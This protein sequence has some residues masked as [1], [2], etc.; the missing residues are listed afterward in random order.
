MYRTTRVRFLLI[1]LFFFIYNSI[2]FFQHYWGNET[3]R[4]Y[5]AGRLPKRH[6]VRTLVILMGNLRGG[7]LAWKSLH[8]NVLDANNAD[9]A[10]MIGEPRNKVDEEK[11]RNSSLYKR[12]RH[13]WTFPEYDDWAD[14]IDLINGSA[15]REKVPPYMLETGT[16]LG[17]VKMKK[18]A[19]SGAVIFMIRYFLSQELVN[20]GML[21]RYDR[22]VITRSDHYYYCK[23]DLSQ[24]DN[25]YM[26]LPEGQN[27]GG[28]TDRHLVV[29]STMV[30]R[31]L[32]ILP[33]VIKNPE[34]YK[35]LL[36]YRSGNP[37]RLIN[38]RWRDLRL[39]RF[40]K[41]FPRMMFTCAV[42]GD[43]TRWQPKTSY[44]VPELGIYL[45]YRQEFF[46]AKKTC[47]RNNE[48]STRS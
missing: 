7:E 13:H 46:S 42:D 33:P 9:L 12:A 40:V 39:H 28:I 23:H 26:W 1:I 18:F 29:N 10:L 2:S 20:H 11:T 43:T 4:S 5:S 47:A 36:K 41:R 3:N 8:E 30:I 16:I 6:A 15:W 35:A 38:R 48:S 32:D 37:E 22:F 44:K 45:K 24:L 19:G 17:G 21:K 31:A 34:S 14:A 27:H 25:N